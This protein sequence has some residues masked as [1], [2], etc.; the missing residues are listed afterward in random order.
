MHESK[1]AGQGPAVHVPVLIVPEGG[2]GPAHHSLRRAALVGTH[3]A[4][5]WS[6]PTT[7]TTGTGTGTTHQRTAVTPRQ[8]EGE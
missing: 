7:G 2:L 6:P 1:R 8:G 5:G 3:Q 4:S